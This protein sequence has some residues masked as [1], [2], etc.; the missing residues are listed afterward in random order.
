MPQLFLCRKKWLQINMKSHHCKNK[1]TVSQKNKT[2]KILTSTY[3]GEH[4]KT[5]D[6]RT[7]EVAEVEVAEDPMD[8][9]SEVEV[10]EAVPSKTDAASILTNLE[11]ITLGTTIA[12]AEEVVG[13]L[14][15]MDIITNTVQILMQ[16]TQKLE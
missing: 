9:D 4:I 1:P 12:A 3:K 2:R 5:K 6:I 10:G 13:V 7:K 14:E 15:D 16:A 11:I 8:V